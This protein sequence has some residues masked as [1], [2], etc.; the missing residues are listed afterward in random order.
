M[1]NLHEE[2]CKTID[3]LL[4]NYDKATI[5]GSVDML[6]AK[7]VANG[8]YN[9]YPCL[10]ALIDILSVIEEMAKVRI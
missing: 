4:A 2:I 9:N 7:G 1:E 10:I 5:T 6:C 8:A 3:N